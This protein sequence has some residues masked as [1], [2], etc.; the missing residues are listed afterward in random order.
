M[1]QKVVMDGS[2]EL[3]VE[4]T[5]LLGTL[6]NRGMRLRVGM[7]LP[8][9]LQSGDLAALLANELS[10]YSRGTGVSTAS[11]IR[12]VNQWFVLRIR[13]NPWL[14][15]LKARIKNRKLPWTRR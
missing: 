13:H 9:G 4:F 5:S 3:R 8:V 1:P 12:D 6:L 7:A 11:F 14:D 10:F 2:A 15:W